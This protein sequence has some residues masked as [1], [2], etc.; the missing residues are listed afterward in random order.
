MVGLGNPGDRYAQTRHN[1]GFMLAERLAERLGARWARW[2]A[3][4]GEYCEAEHAG[5]KLILA[6]PLTYMNESGRMVGDVAR[7]KNVRPAEVLVCY[8]DFALPLGRVRLR[9]KGSAGGHNGMQS[10]IDHLRTQEVPRLRI[11]I[12]PLPPGPDSKDFVLGRFKPQER[13]GLAA[14]LALAEKAVLEAA[15]RGVEAA[16]NRFNPEPA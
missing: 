6:R 2:G 13:D 14:G 12:G 3:E 16:M 1:V 8:D 7:D 5:S 15:E 10:I 4:L 9:L 11:G